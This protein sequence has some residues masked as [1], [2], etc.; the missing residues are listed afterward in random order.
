M[1]IPATW[2]TIAVTLDT[3][4]TFGAAL[5]GQVIFTPKFTGVCAGVLVAPSA[6]AVNITDG[7]MAAVSLP[8]TDDADV[9]YSGTAVWTV[10]YAFPG[11]PAAFDIAVPAAGGSIN[12]A[13]VTPVVAATAMT[14]VSVG[15]GFLAARINDAA[16]QTRTAIDAV[17]ATDAAVAAADAALDTRLD[18]L[19][20]SPTVAAKP[21]SGIE[22]YS[23]LYGNSNTVTVTSGVLKLT[24][25]TADVAL[26]VGNLKVVTGA[27]GSS[28]TA[29]TLCKLGLY[30]VAANGDLTRIAITANDVTMFEVAVSEITRAVTSPVAVTQGTRLALAVLV[31]STG[32]LPQLA[33]A[34][35]S[36]TLAS[37]S[38]R[39]YGQ[40]SSQSDLPA[41]I[42]APVANSNTM[43]YG[44]IL[45]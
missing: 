27:I 32:T 9:T 28:G 10:Y 39:I 36:I 22:T 7:I 14:A 6:R 4:D 29:P 41:T 45:P 24:Y 37:I 38:P 13:T 33:G 1:P 8:A 11:A 44:V 25:F 40:V 42:V 21:T 18:I 3:R 5:T 23:R 12:L 35:P 2:T 30:S 31:V 26:T 16:S 34:T 19:E 17:F 43:H 20:N 15:D